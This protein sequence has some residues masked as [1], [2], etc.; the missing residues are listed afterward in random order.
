MHDT[1]IALVTGASRGI[2]AEVAQLLAHPGTRV[3]NAPDIADE[4]AAESVIAD[5]RQRFGRLDTLILNAPG[6]LAHGVDARA[7]M[8]VNRDAQRRIVELAMPLMPI[9]GRV[10]FVTSH[11]AHFYP[12]KAVPKGYAPI[13]ASMRAGETAMYG[14][15]YEFNRRGIHFTVVSADMIDGAYFAPPPSADGFA[16]AVAGAAQS[17]YHPGIVYVGGGSQYLC[18]A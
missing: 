12:H 7:A 5:I 13:A 1:Q 3:I 16:A 15:R 9:G 10:V 14:M 2:G 17:E 6:V 18:S 11:Q 8:R 4:T